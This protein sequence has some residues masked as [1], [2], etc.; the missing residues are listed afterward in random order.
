MSHFSYLAA[1]F[2][3]TYAKIH[4]TIPAGIDVQRNTGTES[5]QRPTFK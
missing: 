2:L 1:H 4:Y 3:I 5:L